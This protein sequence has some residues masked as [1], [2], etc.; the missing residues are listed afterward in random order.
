MTRINL[1]LSSEQFKY[2]LSRSL[3]VKNVAL[4]EIANQF[5]GKAFSF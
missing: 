5:D 2:I 3:L 1:F 4:G